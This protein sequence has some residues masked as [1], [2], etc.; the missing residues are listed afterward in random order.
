[1]IVTN[2]TKPN[3]RPQTIASLTKQQQQQQQQQQAQPTL[4]TLETSPQFQY[5]TLTSSMP[6]VIEVCFNISP[7]IIVLFY[8]YITKFK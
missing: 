1:M 7:I 4:Q 5:T 8:Y 6:Q 3:N 2:N